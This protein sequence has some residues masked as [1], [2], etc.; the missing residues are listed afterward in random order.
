[1]L[2]RPMKSEAVI[3][4]NDYAIIEA[5]GKQY[6]VSA[7]ETLTTDI[8]PGVNVGDTVTFDRVLLVKEGDQLQVGKPYVKGGQVSAEV[9]K[10]GRTRKILVFKYKRKKRYRRKTGHRQLFMVAR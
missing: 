9:E 3:S 1:M 5:G 8:M 10:L 7:G 4:M 2:K 6:R